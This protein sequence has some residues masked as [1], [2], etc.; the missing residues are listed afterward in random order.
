MATTNKKRSA[1]DLDEYNGETAFAGIESVEAQLIQRDGDESESFANENESD[2]VRRLREAN[3]RL[4]AENRMLQQAI[5]SGQNQTEEGY[6]RMAV[7]LIRSLSV[8]PTNGNASRPT[9]PLEKRLH[10]LLKDYPNTWV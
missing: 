10:V 6:R 1:D 4:D 8:N 3:E 7:E 2:E 9:G 5:R